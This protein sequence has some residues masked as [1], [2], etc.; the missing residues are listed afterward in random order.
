MSNWL[1]IEHDFKSPVDKVYAFLADH[2]NLS[3]IFAPMRVTRIRE[4]HDSPN[5]EGSVRRLSLFGLLPPIEETIV[6]AKPNEV[7][8]YRITNRSPLRNHEGIM[9][10]EPLPSGGTHMVYRI[11][12]ESAL[13]GLAAIVQL[14]LNDGI[15]RGLK[16]VDRLI[17]RR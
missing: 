6:E 10:F 8:R 15:R 12:L 16:Q 5:G 14:A 2:G 4:G 11:R 3:T 17:A 13:P 7:I 9:R 1:Q